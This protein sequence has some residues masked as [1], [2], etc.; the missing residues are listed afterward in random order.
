LVAAA[1]AAG[2]AGAKLSGAGRGGNMIALLADGEDEG[3]KTA[4]SAALTAA[5]AK[6]VLTTVLK[7]E[8]G[9]VRDLEIGY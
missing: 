5:G 1:L 3:G 8:V 6:N 4:V 2:A 7:G 9:R